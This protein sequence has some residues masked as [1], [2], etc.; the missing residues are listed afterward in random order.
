MNGKDLKGFIFVN[1]VMFVTMAACS[2]SG[3]SSESEISMYT[4][5]ML[6]AIMVP[7]IISFGCLSWFIIKNKI[8]TLKRDVTFL[9][10]VIVTAII[11]LGLTELLGFILGVKVF[12]AK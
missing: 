11:E 12:G 4:I 9:K 6:I 7:I 3:L 2:Y 1:I 10:I 5:K 8:N